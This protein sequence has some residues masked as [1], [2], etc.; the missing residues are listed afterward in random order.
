VGDGFDL[1]RAQRRIYTSDL[2]PLERLVALAICDF[3]S[4]ESPRPYPSVS[5]LEQWTGLCRH[6]VVKALSG[7]RQRGA[8]VALSDGKGKRTAYDL[9]PLMAL[10]TR[11]ADQCTPRTG[12]GGTG[13]RDAPAEPAELVHETHRGG[14]RG[15]PELVH[16][17]HP[18]EP[19]KEP[20]KEPSVG[21][22]PKP[23][24]PKTSKWR[25]VPSDWD[26]KPEHRELA[27]ELGVNLEFEA[28]KYKD[29]EFRTPKSDPDATFRNWLRTAAAY[30]NTRP[31]NGARSVQRGVVDETEANNW[32]RQG[33][34]RLLGGVQ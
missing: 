10:E 28:A 8:I 1:L 6:A 33:A 15:A 22:R 20:K 32:G 24:A 31:R 11:A 27:A 18:K 19:K 3:W 17:T 25:R 12:S 13:A 14:A 5:K 30:G 9:R 7:L 26:P 34:A 16:E 2:R 4:A 21:A 29:H 23:Q